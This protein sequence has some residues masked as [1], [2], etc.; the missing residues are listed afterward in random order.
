MGLAAVEWLATSPPPVALASLHCV[1]GTATRAARPLLAVALRVASEC[2]NCN[3][4]R[5]QSAAGS[6][7]SVQPLHYCFVRYHQSAQYQRSRSSRS[8]HADSLSAGSRSARPC[9]RARWP[10]YTDCRSIITCC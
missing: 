3:S 2:G 8:V 4:V 6:A 10:R 9:G 5:C 1:G 7:V